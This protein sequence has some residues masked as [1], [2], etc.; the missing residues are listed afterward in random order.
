MQNDIYT[1]AKKHKTVK[2]LLNKI[3]NS[4]NGI[5][6][7]AK[8]ADGFNFNKVD[9]KPIGKTKIMRMNFLGSNFKYMQLADG[10]ADLAK[11]LKDEQNNVFIY[12]KNGIDFNKLNKKTLASFGNISFLT[13]T[14]KKYLTNDNGKSWYEVE[15][16][17]VGYATRNLSD[18][19]IINI[20]NQANFNN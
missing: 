2:D 8:I 9:T 16:F 20:W 5:G 15:V 10:Y 13:K 6:G 11:I 4:L 14:P 7:I 3:D 1:E 18:Q 19:E 12:L 17:E